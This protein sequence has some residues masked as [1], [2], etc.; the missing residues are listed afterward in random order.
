MSFFF[1]FFSPPP[2]PVNFFFN[3]AV[4]FISFFFLKRKINI[5]KKVFKN[6]SIKNYIKIFELF[7]SIT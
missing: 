5:E 6:C 4:T 2:P 7:K 1:F 3:G